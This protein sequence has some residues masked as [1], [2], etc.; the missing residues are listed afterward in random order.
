M[1]I[2]DGLLPELHR[3]HL[4]IEELRKKLDRG[5]RL[6][7]IQEQALAD[8]Q[9]KHES[10][11]AQQ[12]DLRKAVDAKSLQLKT[13]ESKIQDLTGK[14]NAATTN[15]EYE[16]F[17]SQIKAD[18]MANSVLEDEILEG[19]DKVDCC[20]EEIKATELECREQEQKI[21]KTK[22]EVESTRAG[23]EQ[24]AASIE[25]ELHQREQE[26]PTKIMDQYK[27]MVKVHGAATLA[28]VRDGTC[29]SCFSVISPQEQVQLNTNQLIFCGSCGRIMFQAKAVADRS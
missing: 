13:N 3:L 27:R 20:G 19:M 23:L 5:P 15:K 10:L 21:S 22:A 8:L 4:R 7:K 14:L 11:K 16:V 25:E 6:I 1:S 24:Q 17:S 18:E 26:L 12:I 2:P 29:N 28:E 9:Q